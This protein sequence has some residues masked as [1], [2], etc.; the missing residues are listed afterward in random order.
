MCFVVK[1][2]S[3]QNTQNEDTEKQ[4]FQTAFTLFAY[5]LCNELFHF[6]H[7]G[8]VCALKHPTQMAVAVNQEALRNTGKLADLKEFILYIGVAPDKRV[9]E[10]H[11]FGKS[12]YISNTFIVRVEADDLEVFVTMLVLHFNK[13]GHFGTTWTTPGRPHINQNDFAL[14]VGDLE[15]AVIEIF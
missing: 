6:R 4:L 12:I 9:V 10:V 7:I 8:R 1:K 13:P 15:C 14:F 3:P 5:D 2:L 11:F